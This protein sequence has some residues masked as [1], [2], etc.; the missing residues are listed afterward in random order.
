[1]NGQS[2]GRNLLKSLLSGEWLAGQTRA[3][4][5]KLRLLGLLFLFDTLLI[6]AVFLSFQSAE[7]VEEVIELER[8][9]QVYSTVVI[10]K[11]ITYTTVITKVVPYGSI[12]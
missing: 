6:V 7:L 9:R 10:E 8:T 5:S 1:M 2:L 11:I 12:Q 4:K 3:Y